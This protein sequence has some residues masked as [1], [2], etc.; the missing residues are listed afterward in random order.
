VQVERQQGEW[1]F[2]GGYVGDVSTANRTVA[3]FSPER[4]LAKSIVGRASYTIDTN[5]SAAAEALVRQNGDAFYCK[6]EYSWA[7]G[8][9]WRTT[10][11]AALIRGEPDD[12]LGQYDRNS[13]VNLTLRYS[14]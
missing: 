8:Q 4:G 10:V 9:H 11:S 7:R 3:S 12:F 2:T 1:Q 13:H 14:F 6:G 5:R